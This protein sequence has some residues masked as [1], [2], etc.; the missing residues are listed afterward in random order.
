M[1]ASALEI[2]NKILGKEIAG[3][4][5][6]Q[7]HEMGSHRSRPSPFQTSLIFKKTCVKAFVKGCSVK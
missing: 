1:A 3:S 7:W 4:R 2:K 5:S 6:E